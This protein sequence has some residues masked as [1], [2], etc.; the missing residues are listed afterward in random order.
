MP[1][2]CRAD[3]ICLMVECGCASRTVWDRLH[4]ID[5][6]IEDSGLQVRPTI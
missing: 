2:R 5:P 4:Q 1:N 6:K 3:I